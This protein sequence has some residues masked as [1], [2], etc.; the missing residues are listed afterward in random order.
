M[1]LGVSQKKDNSK[2]FQ[3]NSLKN[4]LRRNLDLKN[5][6]RVSRFLTFYSD[7]NLSYFFYSSIVKNIDYLNYLIKVSPEEIRKYNFKEIR[8]LT[9]H[10]AYFSIRSLLKKLLYKYTSHTIA[11]QIIEEAHGGQ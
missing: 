8:F 2:E 11:K 7:K 1:S 5:F 6:Q 3:L 4:C 9:K 10:S